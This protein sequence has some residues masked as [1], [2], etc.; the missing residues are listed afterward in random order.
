MPFY[1]QPAT[2]L[3][4]L[5]GLYRMGKDPDYLNGRRAE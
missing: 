4:K 5:Y 2:L 3:V 1:Y